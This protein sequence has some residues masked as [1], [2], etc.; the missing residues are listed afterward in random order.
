MSG[1]GGFQTQVYNQ[2][3]AA[4]AGDFAS[5]NPFFSYNAGPGGLVAG[6]NGLV[7]GNFAWVFPPLDPN[8]TAQIAQ[9]VGGGNYGPVAGFV[10][11]EQQGLITAFLAF[12]GMTI[13][14][15]TQATLLTGGDFWVVNAGTTE[16][17]PQGPGQAAMKAYAKFSDGSV[18]FAATGAPPQAASVT[19]SIAASTFSVTGSITNNILTVTAVGSGT[20]VQGATISGTGIATGTQ[21][22]SQLT[23]LLA[24]EALGGIGRYYVSIDEQTA[25]STTVSGT[26]GT[27]TVTAVGSGAVIGGGV[28]A[29]AGV[30]AGTAVT[31]FGTGTG[32]TGTY[33]VNNNTV[34]GSTTITQTAYIET[35]WYAMSSGLTGELVKITDHPLG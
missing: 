20:V 34:V 7:I 33:F 8:G 35:K 30:A 26:Y 23:P 11:R 32:G 14:K 24:G 1:T 19:A 31:Q 29:G 28:L 3:N 6:P 10:H 5:N 4:V 21:I 27:M 22:V 2:P 9:N 13:Q 17:L 16:A 25:A 12:A 18:A 15:G